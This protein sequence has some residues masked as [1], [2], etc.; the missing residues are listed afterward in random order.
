MSASGHLFLVGFMGAGKSSVGLVVA[1]RLGRSLIDLDDLIEQQ[2]GRKISEIFAENGE[3]SFR[4][5]ESRALVSLATVPPSV[6]ACG[7]GIVLRAENRTRLKEMGLVVYLEV[8][9]G[10]ALARIG[11]GGTRPLLSGPSGA[12][13]ATSILAARESLYRSVADAVVDTTGRTIAQVAEDVAS[14]AEERGL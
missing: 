4:E 6:V 2:D 3:E 9:A 11:D 7:G 5:M 12:L 10:E 8:T 14:I 1:E 13:A